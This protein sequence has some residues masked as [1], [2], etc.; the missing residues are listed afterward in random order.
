MTD[1]TIAVDSLGGRRR[2]RSRR[3]LRGGAPLD[4]AAAPGLAQ[5]VPGDAEKPPQRARALVPE[6][7]GAQDR[8]RERL[9]R[10]VGGEFGIAR[11]AGEIAGDDRLVTA[12]EHR[13][14]VGVAVGAAAEQLAVGWWL[15][16]THQRGIASW[17][18][19]CDSRLRRTR[20]AFRLAMRRNSTEV[21]PGRASAG[22]SGAERCFRGS[23]RSR[24]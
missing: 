16:W 11:P 4:L 21:P 22:T 18:V 6:A 8:R 2:G 17:T 12:T 10:E 19:A 24:G 20:V 14:R 23:A 13:E 15:A 9:G 1:A 7:G 5:E 3:G